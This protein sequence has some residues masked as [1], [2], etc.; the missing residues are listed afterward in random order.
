[1]AND[2]PL[3]AEVVV[4]AFDDEGNSYSFDAGMAPGNTVT[5]LSGAIDAGLAAEGFDGAGRVAMTLTF[6]APDK[7]IE[8]YSA[9]NVGGADRGTVVN[10]SNG[11]TFFYGTGVTPIP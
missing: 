8:V 9:Y 1:V 5:Q 7:D 10:T 11:R 4:D 6:T 2:G 3:D